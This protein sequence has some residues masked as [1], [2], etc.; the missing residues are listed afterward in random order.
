MG[1]SPHHTEFANGYGFGGTLDGAD[2]FDSSFASR[3]CF[4]RRLAMV[5]IQA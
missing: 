4:V 2:R 1:I 5:D 3:R